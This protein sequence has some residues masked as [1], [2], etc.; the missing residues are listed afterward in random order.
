MKKK[1]SICKIEKDITEFRKHKSCKNG[2]SGWC[3]K[4][5]TEYSKQYK[6]DNSEKIAAQRR[7]RYAETRGLEV[8]ER[9]EKR[10]ELHPVRVRAQTLRSGILERARKT[11]CE[12][13][14]ELF[15]TEYFFDILNKNKFCPCCGREFDVTYKKNGMRKDTSPSV[16]KVIPSKGYTAG[17]VAI[18]CWRCNR[19]KCDATAEELYKIADWVDTW[20][21]E[22]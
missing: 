11:G 6:R 10:R 1:C 21:K 20:G 9:E 16:D 5:A 4:C 13:D 7:K 12:I 22:A 2:R 15:T 17:N 3:K 19:I 18:I 14:K 8:K